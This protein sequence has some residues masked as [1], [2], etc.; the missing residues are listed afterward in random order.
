MKDKEYAIECNNYLDFVDRLICNGFTFEVDLD[1]H[2]MYIPS[3]KFKEETWSDVGFHYYGSR[4][5]YYMS[6]NN[7][8]DLQE[9]IADAVSSMKDYM[10]KVVAHKLNEIIVNH[11]GIDLTKGDK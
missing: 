7:I 5:V 4:V 11:L 10:K 6:I 8:N 1:E 2:R 9:I 3:Y